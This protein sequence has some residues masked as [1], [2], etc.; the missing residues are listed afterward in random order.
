MKN[1]VILFIFIMIGFAACRPEPNHVTR[2]NKEHFTLAEQQEIGDILQIAIEK[3]HEKFPILSKTGFEEAYNYL[4]LLNRTLLAS[5]NVE[6]RNEYSWDISIIR[7]D[8]IKTAFITPGGHLYLYTGLLKFLETEHQ[9][10]AILAHEIA[11]ADSDF[12]INR[13]KAEYGGLVLG[14]LLLG[15]KIENLD[16]MA[17]SL[18]NLAFSGS[19]V[20]SADAYSV[21]LL[22]PFAYDASGIKSILETIDSNDVFV[23]WLQTRRGDFEERIQN[24]TTHAMPCG[25]EGQVFTERYKN[26]KENLLP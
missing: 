18:A 7:N 24:I 4:D 20:L 16:E 26:F 11:Y 6:N 22:C 21:N 14:D 15:N 10:A 8:A 1:R 19:D 13:L 3:N 12:M 9:L 25:S 17:C 23:E 5:P 2:I